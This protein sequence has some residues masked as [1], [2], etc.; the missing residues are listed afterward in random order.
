MKA[1][2]PGGAPLIHTG[3]IPFPPAET[4]TISER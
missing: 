2:T 1:L 3:S 4:G